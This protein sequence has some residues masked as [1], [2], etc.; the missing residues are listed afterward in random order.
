MSKIINAK[1]KFYI[2]T[3]PT[4][5]SL[6]STYKP[7]CDATSITFNVSY[8]KQDSTYFCNGGEVTSTTT[9]RTQT[10]S[11]SIDYDD[12]NEAHKYLLG[13]L[14]DQDFSKCNNQQIKLELP[15]M[16]GESTPT[17]YT[18]K[19]CIQFKNGIPSG[20]AD[21]LIKLE[22]DVAPQDTPFKITKGS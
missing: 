16:D 4:N 13:L 21:E 2:S 20:A 7:V 11:V 1:S 8:K 15:L 9:G 6:D 3:D 12:T 10:L 19:A 18:G 5:S 22:F 14:I 17:T